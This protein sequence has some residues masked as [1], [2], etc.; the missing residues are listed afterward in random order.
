MPYIV[1]SDRSEWTLRIPQSVYTWCWIK[2]PY[3]D[4]NDHI[5]GNR[6]AMFFSVIILRPLGFFSVLHHLVLVPFKLIYLFIRI[7][8]QYKTLCDMRKLKN[9]AISRMN[10]TNKF[11]MILSGWTIICNIICFLWYSIINL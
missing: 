5:W 8:I 2:Y 9:L 7:V 6:L 4:H 11:G 10:T 1:L 3:F